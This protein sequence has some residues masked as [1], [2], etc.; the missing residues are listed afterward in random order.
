MPDAADPKKPDNAKDLLLADYNYI[1]ESLLKNEQGG[2]TRVNLFMTLVTAGIGGLFALMT[3]VA[4]LTGLEMRVVI[5]AG[6]ASLLVV[7]T[8]TWLRMI[9]RDIGTDLFAYRLDLIRQTFKQQLDPAGV[10]A[11]YDPFPRLAGGS[12]RRKFGGLSDTVAVFNGFLAAGIM[13]AVVLP[14]ASPLEDG[15]MLGS[16]AIIALAVG[17][18]VAAFQVSFADRQETECGGSCR[19]SQARRATR[20]AS[21]T[22]RAATPCAT[23]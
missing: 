17:V 13:V 4:G 18:S 16:A 8:V 5:V 12:K 21:C 19:S 3:G 11:Y 7:G 22:R 20:A 1:S 10:L 9:K 15:T 2:E 6:L 23:F 14:A